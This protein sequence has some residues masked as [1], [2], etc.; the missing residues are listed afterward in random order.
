MPLSHNEVQ[1][2]VRDWL[3][4][5]GYKKANT[6]QFLQYS[7][8]L[9]LEPTEEFVCCYEIKSEV[10]SHGEIRQGIMQAIEGL[11]LGAKSYLVICDK[12]LPK[13]D[14]FLPYLPKFGIITYSSGNGVTPTIVRE[15]EL[16]TNPLD[17]S[18]FREVVKTTRKYKSTLGLEP[19]MITSSNRRT[20]AKSYTMTRDGK[21]IHVKSYLRKKRSR[22]Q[23]S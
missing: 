20:R 23:R 1:Q 17:V 2:H 15:P 14:L 13:L 3:T 6:S 21:L 4:D 5:S 18:L 7:D 16:I 9:L 22:R 10:I 12:Y 8:V 19:A 11:L